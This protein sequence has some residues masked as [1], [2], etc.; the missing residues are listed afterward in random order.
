[1]TK[2]KTIFILIVFGI[3]LILGYNT[4]KTLNN[5]SNKYSRSINQIGVNYGNN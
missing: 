4:Y 5:I 3:I 2:L 1:M